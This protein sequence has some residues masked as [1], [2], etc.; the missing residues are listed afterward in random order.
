M[1]YIKEYNPQLSVLFI[2]GNIFLIGFLSISI[3]YWIANRAIRPANKFYFIKMFPAFLTIS[4]GLSLHNTI[5]V[6]EGYFGIKTPFIRTPKFNVIDNKSKW[7]GNVYM[8]PKLTMGTMIEALLSIYFL[9]GFTSGV[10]LHDWGL[11]FFHGLLTIA[12]G[13]IFYQSIKPIKYAGQ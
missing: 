7:S 4:M 10:I 6:L 12:F 2:I 5:A 8:K 13:F 11:L 1:L 3:F 9:F